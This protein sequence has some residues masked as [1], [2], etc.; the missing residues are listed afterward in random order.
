[1]T[2]SAWT[3]RNQ[4]TAASGGF[5]NG[6][7]LSTDATI[8]TLDT[9][10]GSNGNTSLAAG[11][12][13]AW[14]GPT[15]TIPAGTSPGTYYIGILVDRTNASAESNES[16]NFVS[17][18]ITVSIPDAP[19]TISNISQQLIGD[20]SYNCVDAN[21][22]TFP[23]Y[24]YRITVNYQ[25]PNGDVI[26]ADGAKVRLDGSDFQWFSISGDGETGSATADPCYS[27]AQHGRTFRMSVV[28]GASL[29]SNILSITIP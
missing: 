6:F 2:L 8:G 24:Y 26:R 25:D 9:T 10:L 18:Q 15:L 12:Q 4:G 29:E 22:N 19:P 20:G 3:V 16:N 21:N 13:F 23:G 5:S 11:A 14:G 27:S 7:Y 1:M 28:D 17:R